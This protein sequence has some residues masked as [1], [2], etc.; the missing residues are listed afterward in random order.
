MFFSAIRAKRGFT[1]NSTA[2]QFEAAYKRLIVHSEVMVASGD[3][4]LN[5]SMD[6]R[7]KERFTLDI[8]SYIAG[9]KNKGG[10][11]QPLKD[12]AETVFNTNNKIFI[13]PQYLI[14][15]PVLGN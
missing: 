5:Y 1:N 2:T 9:I 13:L 12:A 8:I 10:L 14:Y 15:K 11:T 7:A 4:I 3:V 6:S